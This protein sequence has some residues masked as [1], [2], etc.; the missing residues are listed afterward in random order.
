MP[1]DLPAGP[2][3]RERRLAAG[4][5]QSALARR[6]GISASYLNLIEHGR[7]PLGRALLNKVADALDVD[8]ARLAEGSEDALVRDLRALPGAAEAEADSSVDAFVARFPAWAA[9]AVRE[10]ARA[11]ALEGRVRELTDRIGHDPQLAAALLEVVSAA[12]AIRSSA[13]IL[14]E[15]EV[16]PDWQRRFLRNI[17]ED[18]LRLSTGAEELSRFLRSGHGGGDGDGA[19]QGPLTPREAAERW[20]HAGGAGAAPT[21]TAAAIAAGV[22]DRLARDAAL[23]PDGAVRAARAEGAR[24]AAALSARLGVPPA[25]AVRRL[26]ALDPAAGMVL[27]DASGAPV[28]RLPPEGFALPRF[29][30]LCPVLPL[31]EALGDPG[32]PV[33]A[34]LETPD[35]R[36]WL[37]EAAADRTWPAGGAAA[38]VVEAAMS[39]APA[40]VDAPGGAPRPV[41]PGCRLCPR[42]ACPARREP[43]VA[44][45]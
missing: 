6:C 35:G 19:G 18:S 24:D 42:A 28:V 39:I 3:I 16:D 29:G 12:T 9:L 40:P 26:A 32:R 43:A 45:A 2:R 11:A 41:G 4:I 22:A 33:R 14:A 37:A 36:R 17:R 8:P 30:G 7:R 31:Y 5:A 10:G 44:S 38:P 23:A 15:G 25:V 1:R 34:V 13:S 20:L 21:G 27:A